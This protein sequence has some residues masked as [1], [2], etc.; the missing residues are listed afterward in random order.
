MA[1]VINKIIITAEAV[2]DYT[3]DLGLGL[4]NKGRLKADVEE[5]IDIQNRSG[6]LMW[7][8]YFRCK[9]LDEGSGE[10]LMLFLYR[11]Y[12]LGLMQN[13]TLAGIC[14][15]EDW[16]EDDEY[17]GSVRRWLKSKITDLGNGDWVVEQQARAE[18]EELLYGVMQ[19]SSIKNLPREV[20]N[21]VKFGTGKDIIEAVSCFENASKQS[22]RRREA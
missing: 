19:E 2:F 22:F 12:R 14:F 20:Q 8:H 9:Y 1:E 21:A 10:M 7:E 4:L 5:Y 18:A 17:D 16:S 13:W 15:A 3:E 6:R 11:S